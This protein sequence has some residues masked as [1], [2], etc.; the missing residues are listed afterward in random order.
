MNLTGFHKKFAF[1]IFTT[2]FMQ[3]FA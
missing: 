3:P 2:I 1:Y